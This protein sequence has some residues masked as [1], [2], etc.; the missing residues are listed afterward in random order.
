M[1]VDAPLY[2][3]RV[4]SIWLRENPL[5]SR[6]SQMVYRGMLSESFSKTI[7]TICKSF[8]VS[9][10]FSINLLNTYI[11][12]VVDFPSIWDHDPNEGIKVV[13]LG[14]SRIILIS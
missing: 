4:A 13:G 9:L 14:D 5:G 8:F 12:S 6:F 11:A 3:S 10:Y 1:L 7:N 2:M